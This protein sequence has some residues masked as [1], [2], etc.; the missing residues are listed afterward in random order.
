M[1]AHSSKDAAPRPTAA[2][3]PAS[4]VA[5]VSFDATGTLFHAPRLASIYA[6]T[7]GR[8]GVDADEATLRTLLPDDTETRALGL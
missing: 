7:L 1:C 5:A 3:A 2:G 8:H 6:E 4:L